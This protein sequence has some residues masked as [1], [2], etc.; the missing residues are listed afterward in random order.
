MNLTILSELP[1]S[2]L[3][4]DIKDIEQVFS[5]PTLIHL[6]PE[7]FTHEQPI[8]LSILLHGNE[9]SGFYALREV[10]KKKRKRPLLI[11]I[12][13]PQA[14]AK[15]RRFLDEQVD[16]N[17][18]WQG[19]HHP[20]AKV[21]QD[22]INYV[23]KENPLL[24]IDIHNNSGKNP[25]YSC[26]NR[27]DDEFL[28]LARFFSPYVV[29]FTEPHEVQS[30]AFSKF[31]P[32][33]TIEAGQSGERKGIETL[34]NK[35][36]EVL[37][38]EEIPP[39]QEQVVIYH[40]VARFRIPADLTYDFFNERSSEYELCLREDIEDYNFRALPH[41]FSLGHAKTPH[42]L[43]L[44]GDHG[45]NSFDEYLKWQDG[46]ILV[47]KSFIPAMLTTNRAIIAEDCLG[48]VM[49]EWHGHRK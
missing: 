29:Y 13:N 12:A 42:G 38:W 21:A 48:Y 47:K 35:L 49:E 45:G 1:L 41:G 9:H 28:S 36:I 10:L 14:A 3:E 24:S 44:E 7:T 34:V 43:W 22:V 8:F 27:T 32:A 46:Q 26:I 18:V 11:F 4:V 33:I 31:C 16:F 40:T 15:N 23:R 19:G 37:D 39:H 30:M 20:Q 2:F 17:R 6:Q 25:F 5:G